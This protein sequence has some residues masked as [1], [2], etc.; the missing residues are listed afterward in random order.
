MTSQANVTV[1][2]LG[3]EKR[4]N[5]ICSL[6]NWYKAVDPHALM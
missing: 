6:K 2:E 3:Q 1:S 4:E 5:H